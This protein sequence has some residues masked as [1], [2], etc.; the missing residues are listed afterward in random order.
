VRRE[1]GLHLAA[2]TMRRGERCHLWV[3]PARG[4]GAEGSFSFPT[5]PPAAALTYELELLDWEP[6]N[7][8]REQRDMTYEERLE[9]A[10]R[11]RAEGNAAFQAGRAAEAL[12]RYRAALSFVDEDLLIQLEGPHF[13]RAMAARTPALL[14]MAACH[15]RLG[16][17]ADAIGAA[18]QVLQNDPCNAKALFRR[19]AARRALGQTEAAVG[20]LRAAAAAAPGDGGIARELAAVRAEL[21]AERRAGEALFRGVVDRPGGLGGEGG[22]S[23]DEAAGGAEAAAGAGAVGGAPEGWLSRALRAVCPFIFGRGKAHAA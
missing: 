22:G 5:V 20:D 13:E 16:E 12:G 6:P 3:A 7:E 19:G 4:Y 2:A 1:A 17:H 10:E 14:N 15:L 23:D 18:S 8:D 9:A 21:R 11:R